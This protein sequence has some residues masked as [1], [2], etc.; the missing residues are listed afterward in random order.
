MWTVQAFPD[1]KLL[2]HSRLYC[3]IPEGRAL[4]QG[5]ASP[6]CRQKWDESV[7]YQTME[8]LTDKG[9]FF[10]HRLPVHTF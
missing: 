2:E 9:G 5:K 3:R 10:V 8:G 4:H 1:R 6:A 7:N